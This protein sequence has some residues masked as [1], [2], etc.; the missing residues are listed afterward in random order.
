MGGIAPFPS[1]YYDVSLVINVLLNFRCDSKTK[2][3]MEISFES[4]QIT[5]KLSHNYL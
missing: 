1:K 5:H 2:L 4:G 3:P